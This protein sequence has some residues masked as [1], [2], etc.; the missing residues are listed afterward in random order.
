LFLHARL[1]EFTHPISG[2]KM[3]FESPLPQNLQ[4]VLSG[5]VH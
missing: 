4:D 2:K 3:T 1:L 5:L